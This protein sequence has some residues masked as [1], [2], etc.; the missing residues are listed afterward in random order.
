MPN[1]GDFADPLTRDERR[2]KEDED[3]AGRSV[4][5]MQMLIVLMLLA[6]LG[7]GT[8]AVTRTVRNRQQTPNGP[9]V[10]LAP[11]APGVPAA[12]AQQQDAPQPRVIVE[13]TTVEEREAPAPA[14]EPGGYVDQGSDEAPVPGEGGTPNHDAE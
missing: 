10:P 6:A 13:E 9:S 12:P 2:R 3:A 14:P 1:P 5:G 11:L 4:Q 8:C 7:W